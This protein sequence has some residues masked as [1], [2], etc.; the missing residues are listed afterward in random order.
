[1]KL[2]ITIVCLMS[3]AG[4]TVPFRSEIEELGF[5]QSLFW[6]STLAKCKM[7]VEQDANRAFLKRYRPIGLTRTQCERLIGPPTQIS[8]EPWMKDQ[9]ETVWLCVYRYV[10]E[11]TDVSL[12]FD[13]QLCVTATLLSGPCATWD[14]AFHAEVD[15]KLR[16]ELPFQFH[17]PSA[18]RK[19]NPHSYLPAARYIPAAFES[20][21]CGD[22][23]LKD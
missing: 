18:Q 12:I 3:I 5:A 4:M 14:F 16:D 13:R 9:K 19:P 11:N 22:Q 10:E 23:C 7:S 1:M 6:H 17:L 20:P 2:Y 15:R 8:E 21:Y